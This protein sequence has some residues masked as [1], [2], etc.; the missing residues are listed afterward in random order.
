ME[1]I[2]SMSSRFW[3]P[4]M[5]LRASA[6]EAFAEPIIHDLVIRGA[7]IEEV[8]WMKA[9]PVVRAMAPLRALIDYPQALI[10]LGGHTVELRMGLSHYAVVKWLRTPVQAP[11]T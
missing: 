5:W 4:V 11:G 8:D 3:E 7:Q 9:Q 1:P 6:D 10:A 2:A